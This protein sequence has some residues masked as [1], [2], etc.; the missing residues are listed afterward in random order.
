MDSVMRMESWAKQFL[1][2]LATTSFHSLNG[3][4]IRLR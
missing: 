2:S 1:L 3:L 4:E